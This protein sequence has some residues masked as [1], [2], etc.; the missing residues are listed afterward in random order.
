M[1]ITIT[2]KYDL[3]V[4][5][6]VYSTF[7]LHHSLTLFYTT[8]VVMTQPIALNDPLPSAILAG[9][10]YTASIAPIVSP[11]SCVFLADS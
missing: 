2:I 4:L 1:V 6:A 10:L 9:S 5:C 7:S 8:K 3:R 11:D